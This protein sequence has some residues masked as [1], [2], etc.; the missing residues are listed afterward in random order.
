VKAW[1]FQPH[2]QKAQTIVQHPGF[3]ALFDCPGTNCLVAGSEGVESGILEHT[4]E[5]I[6]SWAGSLYQ[7][8]RRKPVAIC[9][10]LDKGPLV[11]ALREYDFLVLF[12]VN[13]LTLARYRE[14]FATSGAKDDPS[15]A[16]LQLELLIKHRDR[17]KP[18]L[19]SSPAIQALQLLVE[20]R[21]HLVGDKVRLISR[22]TSVLKCYYPQ[23][24]IWF[25]DRGTTLFCDFLSQWPTLDA[26]QRARSSTIKRFF[27]EHHVRSAILIKRRLEGIKIAKP[28]TTNESIIDP[29]RLLTQALLTQLRETLA[30]IAQFDQE[31][32][33]CAQRHPDFAQFDA[34][35]GAGLALVPR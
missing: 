23:V 21:R 12:P 26:V 27:Y 20:H 18:L 14:A 33:Q 6:A 10:E 32:A 15:D 5:A 11:Y 35:P 24:L 9:L 16:R 17:L 25:E 13:P 28:L 22:L 19:P 4:P 8:F 31:I 1:P 3:Q 34:L 2:L 7:R 29:N 30:A